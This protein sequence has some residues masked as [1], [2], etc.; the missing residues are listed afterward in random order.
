MLIKAEKGFKALKK[1]LSIL[2]RLFE[3]HFNLR[4][5]Q[6]IKDDHKYQFT[7]TFSVIR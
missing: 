5:K 6:D 1:K 7:V 2:G 4:K 3:S